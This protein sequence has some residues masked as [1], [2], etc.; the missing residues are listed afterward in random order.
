M[1]IDK[2]TIGPALS[3]ILK[4]KSFYRGYVPRIVGIGPMRMSFWGSMDI[5]E[6]VWLRSYNQ[7]KVKPIELNKYIELAIVGIF[8]SIC[9][10]VIDSQI[11]YFK[12]A[13]I[14]GNHTDFVQLLRG[15]APTLARNMG[16]AV[17]FKN[18]TYEQKKII[19]SDNVYINKLL[20]PGVGGAVASLATQFLDNA[21]TVVQANNNVTFREAL[22]QIN[23]RNFMRGAVPRATLGFFNMGIGF[24][25]FNFLFTN[26]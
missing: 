7:R 23:R 20:V 3:N 26:L 5:M 15:F 12:T 10:T 17:V 4:E 25:A 1:Q 8:G 21:K 11:E 16:F 6:N 14:S 13:K 24:F 9:Q 19:G 22:M 18:V 2:T